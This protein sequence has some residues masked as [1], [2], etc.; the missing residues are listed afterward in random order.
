MC[1]CIISKLNSFQAF[2]PLQSAVVL[3]VILK[4]VAVQYFKIKPCSMEYISEINLTNLI[5]SHQIYPFICRE[6]SEYFH[7]STPCKD[8]YA[9]LMLHSRPCQLYGITSNSVNKI[10]FQWIKVERYC[11]WTSWILYCRAI[12]KDVWYNIYFFTNISSKTVYSIQMG[13]NVS[14]CYRNHKVRR[15]FLNI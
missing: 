10:F 13:A 15:H 14:R 11:R 1:I 12:L 6:P 9:P 2:V 7:S 8:R 5:L 3:H 4:S